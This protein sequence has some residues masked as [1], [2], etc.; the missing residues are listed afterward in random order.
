MSEKQREREREREREMEIYRKREGETEEHGI[1]RKGRGGE[2]P[3]LLFQKR[4]SR[5]ITRNF[6]K[7]QFR[8]NMVSILG[9]WRNSKRKRKQEKKRVIGKMTNTPESLRSQTANCPAVSVTF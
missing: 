4:F 1:G 3:L 2:V 5:S 6:L 7:T 9:V 8:S